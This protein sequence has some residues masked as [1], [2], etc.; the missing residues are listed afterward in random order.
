MEEKQ[1]LSLGILRSCVKFWLL[2]KFT[3]ISFFTI[4]IE[5]P[6]ISTLMLLG[7]H[8]CPNQIIKKNRYIK[9]Q[10]TNKPTKLP[11]RN[12]IIFLGIF[13]DQRWGFCT[14]VYV[15]VIPSNLISW[16]ANCRTQEANVIKDTQETSRIHWVL[17]PGGLVLWFKTNL[18]E[19]KPQVCCLVARWC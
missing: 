17:E 5:S 16:K 12:K 11:L 14:Y 13:M 18:P 6:N 7:S 15:S 10:S 19:F 1:F 3:I 2:K 4:K 9:L 8:S